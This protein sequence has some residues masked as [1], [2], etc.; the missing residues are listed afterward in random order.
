M[1]GERREGRVLPPSGASGSAS[2]AALKALGQREASGAGGPHR[3][4]G[5]HRPRPPPTRD[6]GGPARQRPG[7][8]VTVRCS[9]AGRVRTRLQRPEAGSAAAAAAASFIFAAAAATCQRERRKR[10][11]Q[12]RQASIAGFG[13]NSRAVW[14][15]HPAPQAP[16]GRREGLRVERRGEVV[17]RGKE[18]KGFNGRR[19][20]RFWGH[21]VPAQPSP[22]SPRRVRTALS[23]RGD[24]P[25]PMR[26]NWGRFTKGGEEWGGLPAPP[27]ILVDCQNPADAGGCHSS[28]FF[29]AEERGGLC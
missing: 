15:P 17:G 23:A 13:R 10:R 16:R 14:N 21:P 6:P 29:S 7:N 5:S 9:G 8:G 20:P 11:W 18:G 4:E 25:L 19:E 28:V 3:A 2:N 1:C 22:F 24:R 27:G 26:H 12:R